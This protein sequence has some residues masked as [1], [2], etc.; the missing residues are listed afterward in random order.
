MNTLGV[1]CHT[2]CICFKTEKY[3]LYTV[4]Q[5]KSR[6]I[7]VW[8]KYQKTQVTIPLQSFTRKLAR[9]SL[10]AALT[11]DLQLNVVVGFAEW[12]RCLALVAAAVRLLGRRDQELGAHVL[13]LTDHRDR[14]PSQRERAKAAVKLL[15]IAGLLTAVKLLPDVLLLTA[16]KLLIAVAS[17][18]PVDSRLAVASYCTVLSC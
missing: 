15:I 12:V 2:K 6:G 10:S 3:V 14:G 11:P 5:V 7:K 8:L 17:Y 1:Y 13:Q 18:C 16:V 4:Q 9:L